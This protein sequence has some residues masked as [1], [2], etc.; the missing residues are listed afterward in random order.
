[1]SARRAGR[2]ETTWRRSAPRSAAGAQR[3]RPRTP[4]DRGAAEALATRERDSPPPRHLAVDPARARAARADPTDLDAAIKTGAFEGL[5]RAVRELGPDGHDRGGRGERPARPRRR[6]LPD[7]RRS[8]ARR[9]E[10]LGRAPLRGRER[11]RRRPVGEHGPDARR[12]RPV[13]RHRGR[14][15]SPHS[16]S[17]PREAIIAVRAEATEA[18]RRLEAAVDGRDRRNFIG[19]DALGSGHGASR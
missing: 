11:L 19:D 2:R 3:P 12:D 4:D 6:G 15:R 17:A 5:R 7:R 18:I 10:T 1:M 13:C 8:G 14:W 9:P 16:R